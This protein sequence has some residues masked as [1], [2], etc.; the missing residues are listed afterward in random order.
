MA[1]AKDTTE[2]DQLL[3]RIEELETAG[4][5]VEDCLKAL[6][7]FSG[8]DVLIPHGMIDTAK[9]FTLVR[10]YIPGRQSLRLRTS[11]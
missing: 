2:R 10:D 4:R 3:K 1:K 8:N 9:D 11:R 7:I 6:V 5:F